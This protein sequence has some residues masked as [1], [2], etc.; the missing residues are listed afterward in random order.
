MLYPHCSVAG[1]GICIVSSMDLV[2]VRVLL[3]VLLHHILATL[4]AYHFRVLGL[5][6][7]LLHCL[8]V[9]VLAALKLT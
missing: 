3:H 8:L 1:L 7:V 4:F 6:L 9:P 5:L 2:F